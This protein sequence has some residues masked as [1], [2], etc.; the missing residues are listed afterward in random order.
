MYSMVPEMICSSLLAV[1]S[2]HA[3]TNCTITIYA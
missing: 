1:Y 2:I 3:K